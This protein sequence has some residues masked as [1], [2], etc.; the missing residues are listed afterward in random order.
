MFQ[1]FS[2]AINAGVKRVHLLMQSTGGLV[3]DGIAIYNYL[4]NLPIEITTYNG[5][6]VQSI[7]VLVYLAGKVRKASRNA[8]FLIH[9][10]SFGFPVNPTAEMMR[11]RADAAE[12]CDKNV[13]SILRA[14][15]NMPDERWALRDRSD[16]IIAAAEAVG[17]ALV[18]EIG[19]FTPPPG[20]QLYNI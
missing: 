18:H 20:C 17:F 10:T 8:S 13:D 15:I 16:I 2:V 9:K 14:H 5:G 1:A 11:L 6:S 3:D 12:H 4:S 7:A 19:N